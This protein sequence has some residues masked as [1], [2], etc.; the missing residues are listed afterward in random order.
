MRLLI[1]GPPGVGKGTQAAALAA[2]LGI[3]TLSTG[4]IFRRNVAD[5]TPLGREASVY[6]DAGDYVP[7]HVT[8]AMV[9]D[10]LAAPE[11]E[12]GF[13]LDGY[14]RTTAQVDELDSIL[15]E[16]DRALDAVLVLT[17]DQDELVSRL[18]ARARTDGRTDDSHEVIVRRQEV[19]S[20]QT[21]PLIDVY[22]ARGLLVS[23]DGMG[24]VS[25]VTGRILVALGA[26][27]GP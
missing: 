27:T 12:S 22:G 10:Q 9:R 4:D 2:E 23:V 1:M 25:E 15:A 24:S 21:A 26:R 11:C 7:D 17:T 19:Y 5:G 8:N 13:L 14:P 20:E 18:L 16:N 6:L 3:V